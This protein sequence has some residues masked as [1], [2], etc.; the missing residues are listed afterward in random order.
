MLLLRDGVFVAT[1]AYSLKYIIRREYQKSAG[2]IN[3]KIWLC[4][5]WKFEHV[6]NM[7]QALSRDRPRWP[8]TIL[9]A[10]LS[11]TVS[12]ETVS[13][14]QVWRIPKA[15]H[16]DSPAWGPQGSTGKSWI[17]SRRCIITVPDTWLP[18]CRVWEKNGSTIE[19]T[20]IFSYRFDKTLCP[21]LIGLWV[22]ENKRAVSSSN[23]RN[24]LKPQ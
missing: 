10:H 18:L 1:E 8:N 16:A 15:S 9:S 3:E 14:S 21:V 7:E 20:P 19:T 22:L 6:V 2:T 4:K 13:L 23:V 12:Q 5:N 17:A 24:D 11:G